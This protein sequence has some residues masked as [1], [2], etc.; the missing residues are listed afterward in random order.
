MTVPPS[1]VH[2]GHTHGTDDRHDGLDAAGSEPYWEDFYRQ[3]ERVWSGKANPVLVAVTGQLEP[4]SALDV[5]CGEG[6]DA[7]WLAG[8]GWQVTA[9]DVSSTVLQRA[10]ASAATAGVGS[11]VDWQRHDLAHSFPRG[12]FDLVSCQYLHSPVTFPRDQV[13][14]AAARAVAPGGL[15]LIVGHA[16]GP[17][18]AED[19]DPD[20]HFPTPEEVLAAL[21]LPPGRWRTDLAEVSARQATSPDGRSGTFTDS[22]V[23]VTRLAESEA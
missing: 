1:G 5:G 19:H 11:Q 13:L 22:V 23:A 18:W 21:D 16:A 2:E 14:R 20:F 4:R 9:V 6:G 15:L 3:A 8:R 7:I 12:T 17:P 10:A